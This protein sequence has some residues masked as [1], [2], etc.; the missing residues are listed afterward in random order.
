MKTTYLFTLLAACFCAASPVLAGPLLASDLDKYS[1]MA[2]GYATYGAASDVSGRVGASSYVTPGDGSTS[3]PVYTNTTGVTLALGA[4]AS[5]QDALNR[6]GTGTVLSPTMA[7]SVTLAPG[8]Y[9]ASALTTAAGTNLILDGGGAADPYWIFNIPTYLS[10]GA[11]T[12]ISI[13]N[14]GPTASVVWNMGGYASLGASTAFIGAILSTA[15]ITQGA[16]VTFACGNAFS[17][18][19]VSLGAAVKMTS[20]NCLASGTWEGSVAGMGSG[21]DIVDGVA[22]QRAQTLVADTTPTDVTEP[23]TLASLVLGLGLLILMSRRQLFGAG[24]NKQ[25]LVA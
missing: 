15:Y 16:E 21:L 23:G 10:T 18:S 22:V 25:A 7:G 11:S 6:M 2:G 14:T 12:N 13:I 17:K 4:L 9:S 3:G 5:A 8:V 20:T 24:Q 19:Y 1:I